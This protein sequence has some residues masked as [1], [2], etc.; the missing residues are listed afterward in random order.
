MTSLIGELVNKPKI[1]EMYFD[2]F[3]VQFVDHGLVNLRRN[4]G[5]NYSLSSKTA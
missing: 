1:S 3:L 4:F 5:E 2:S